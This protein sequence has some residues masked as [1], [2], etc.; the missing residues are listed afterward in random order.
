MY[1]AN[2]PLAFV[3]VLGTEK[4]R[5]GTQIPQPAPRPG[6]MEYFLANRP[7]DPS[8]TSGLAGTKVRLGVPAAPEPAP[9]WRQFEAPRTEPL[10]PLERDVEELKASIYAIGVMLKTYFEIADYVTKPA[11]V[12]MV[13]PG[14]LEVAG[15][16]TLEEA[17]ALEREAARTTWSRTANTLQDEMALQAA[18]EGA[19]ETIIPELGGSQV[20]EDGKGQRRSGVRGGPGLGGALRA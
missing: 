18:K 12:V 20:P 11:Q 6:T 13:V 7:S 4:S 19:G 1:A 2:N 9:E 17:A 3:D 16:L 14:A 5:A 10:S 8:P 15:G